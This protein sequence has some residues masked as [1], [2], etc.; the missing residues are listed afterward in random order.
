MWFYK[1]EKEGNDIH[2]TWNT[3]M[4][5]L[6]NTFGFVGIVACLFNVVWL[7]TI[8]LGT[9]A[10]ALAYY[11]YRYGDLVKILHGLERKDI[12][13]Y[14]GSQYS[15]KNPLIVTIPRVNSL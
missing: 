3:T 10:I 2:V 1:I 7:A 13:K 14:T 8:C 6:K 11:V 15:F 12:L 5:Y 4:T 9:L